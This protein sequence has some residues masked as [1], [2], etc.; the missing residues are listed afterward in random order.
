MKDDFNIKKNN[1][2]KV[3]DG[4][5]DDFAER[6]QNMVQSDAKELKK[7]RSFF[8]KP[9][10]AIAGISAI[11]VVVISVFLFDTS[12]QTNE[13]QISDNNQTDETGL[14]ADI[15]STYNKTESLE[16]YADLNLEF[17]S[18]T[19]LDESTI[20]DEYI[21]MDIIEE[22]EDVFSLEEEEIVDYLVDYGVEDYLLL[23]EL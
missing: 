15:D 1:P 14:I 10:Y 9:A 17:V 13:F 18:D 11:I 3:P 16:Q 8:L 20:V 2:F 23:A 5:F 22:N 7:E 21:E 12:D 19:Y 4:Y 6:M